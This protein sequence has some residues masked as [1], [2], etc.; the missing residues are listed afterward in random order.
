MRM[1]KWAKELENLLWI[2]YWEGLGACSPTSTELNSTAAIIFWGVGYDSGDSIPT[3]SSVYSAAAAALLKNGWCTRMCSLDRG[4]KLSTPRQLMTSTKI[5]TSF[6]T[7][8]QPS[9]TISTT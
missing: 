1:K 9:P 7:P 5:S 8:T 2:S 6:I 4:K 3:Q